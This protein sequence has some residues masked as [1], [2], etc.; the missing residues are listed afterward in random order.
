MFGK[1]YETSYD[2]FLLLLIILCHLYNYVY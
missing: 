1:I 2:I